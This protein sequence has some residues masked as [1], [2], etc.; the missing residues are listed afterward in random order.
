MARSAASAMPSAAL[1]LGQPE[2]GKVTMRDK[3]HTLLGQ[4]SERRL[5][6]SRAAI[7][8]RAPTLLIND[9]RSSTF[10]HAPTRRLEMRG[11]F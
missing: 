11:G 2:I 4:A 8:I 3:T 10:F 6:Y 5:P 1:R 9:A 7:E